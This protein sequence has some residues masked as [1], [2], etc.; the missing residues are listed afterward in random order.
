MHKSEVVLVTRLHNT[1]ILARK[2]AGVMKIETKSATK[3]LPP[4]LDF[5]ALYFGLSR[6]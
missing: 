2:L 3:E 4:F 1:L 5:Q 6:A